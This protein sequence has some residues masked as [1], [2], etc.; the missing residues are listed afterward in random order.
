MPGSVQVAAPTYVLP[1]SLSRAF[2]EVREYGVLG[3]SYPD[4]SS[5]RSLETT[6][7]RKRFAIGK[8]LT[9]TEV[10]TLRAFYEARL[11]P[12]Q[13]FYFYNPRETDP[14]FMLNP[15]GVIGRYSVRFDGVWE[16]SSGPSRSEVSIELVELA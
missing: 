13:P 16:Q 7:S 9:A 3:N 6:T 12:H 2:T 5:Q 11:G 1:V 8:R 14:P 10:A 15:T 4:G